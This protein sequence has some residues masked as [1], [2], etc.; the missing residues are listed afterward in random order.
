MY[1]PKAIMSILDS[2]SGS[3]YQNNLETRRRGEYVYARGCIYRKAAKARDTPAACHL[4]IGDLGPTLG[5]AD[6]QPGR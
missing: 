1:L 4:G 2:I 3:L 6:R 5:A